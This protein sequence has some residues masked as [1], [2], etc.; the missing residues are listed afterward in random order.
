MEVSVGICFVIQPFDGARFDK[1]YEDVFVPAIVDAD[2][3]PYRVDR[4]P[5]ATIPIE[6]IEEG[7]RRS[8]ACLADISTDN[9]NVW[10]ELGFAIA[11]GKPVIIVCEQQLNRRFPFDVQHRAI[12][13]YKAESSRDFDDLQQ[14]I[15]QRLLAAIAKG[16]ALENVAEYS[17]TVDVEGLNQ[18]EIAALIALGENIGAPED[19]VSAWSIRHDLEQVGYTRIAITLALTTLLRKGMIHTDKDHDMNGDPYYVYWLSNQGLSWLLDNQHM[20]VMKR[21]T[22]SKSQVEEDDIPF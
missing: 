5:A 16:D 13:T 4:D 6:Q 1:R 22:K 15:T 19:R 8:T 7:I 3:D 21:E 12:I 2:L 18:H 11:S 20:L 10:F 14:Q 9:P 17:R